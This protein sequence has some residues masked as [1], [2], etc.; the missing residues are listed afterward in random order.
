MLDRIAQLVL[1]VFGALLLALLVLGLA[2]SCRP[3]SAG[4]GAV[5]ATPSFNSPTPGGPASGTVI[6]TLIVPPRQ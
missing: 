2:V 4:P 6:A 1:V 5:T 3:T